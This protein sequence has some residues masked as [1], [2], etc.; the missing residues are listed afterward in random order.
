MLHAAQRTCLRGLLLEQQQGTTL[1][2]Y[3]LPARTSERNRNVPLPHF[4]APEFWQEPRARVFQTFNAR[5]ARDG[6][7]PSAGAAHG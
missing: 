7:S 3:V 4:I 2:D 5:I 6:L 1:E